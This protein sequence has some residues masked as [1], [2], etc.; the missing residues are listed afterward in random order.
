MLFCFS[1]LA[2]LE[3]LEKI[4]VEYFTFPGWKSSIEQIRSYDALPDNC[5]KY[6]EFIEEFLKVPV[7]WI[8]VGPA[9]ESMVTKL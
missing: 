4:E 9:R 8:G 2:D 7:K 6:V 1:T 5:K 3:I